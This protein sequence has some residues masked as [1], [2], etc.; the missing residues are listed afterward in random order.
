MIMMVV[1]KTIETKGFLNKFFSHT[2]LVRH[3][4]FSPEKSDFSKLTSGE[5]DKCVGGKLAGG[6]PADAFTFF[7][8][9]YLMNLRGNF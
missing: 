6:L 2:P 8:I 5:K 4:F 7:G 1:M 3:V 9:S